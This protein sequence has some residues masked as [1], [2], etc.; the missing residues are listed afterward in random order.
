MGSQ[1]LFS[2]YVIFNHLFSGTLQKV[3]DDEDGTQVTEYCK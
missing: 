1:S 2:V 3:S